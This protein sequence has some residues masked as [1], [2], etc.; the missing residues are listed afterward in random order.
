M[1]TLSNNDL[2]KQI[3]RYQNCIQ[4]VDP[5]EADPQRVSETFLPII[6]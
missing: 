6:L 2:I 4:Q 3:K 1:E 5:P